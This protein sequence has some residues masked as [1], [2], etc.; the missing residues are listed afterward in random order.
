MSVLSHF[1][2]LSLL[3]AFGLFT[4]LPAAAQDQG[5]V[6]T[7]ETARW[8]NGLIRFDQDGIDHVTA[9]ISYGPGPTG[10]VVY[11]SQPGA[12]A[13]RVDPFIPQGGPVPE[14]SLRFQVKRGSARIYDQTLS[15]FTFADN[16][17]GGA[18]PEKLAE[19]LKAGSSLQITDPAI[20][21]DQRYPLRGSSKALS[22][23]TCL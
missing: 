9:T 5:L 10:L 11:C 21:L 8:D 7:Y 1:R 18:I 3:L 15:G 4:A 23:L 17:Y 13:L 14:S 19:A 20:G 6:Q 2:S 16:S 22:S 12:I